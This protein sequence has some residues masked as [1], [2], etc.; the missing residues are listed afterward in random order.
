MYAIVDIETTG[1]YAAANGITEIAIVLHD[2]QSVTG[3]FETLINPCQP[4]PPYISAMTGISQSMADQAPSFADVAQQIYLLLHDKVF[5][6][7][8]VNFDYSFIKAHLKEAGFDLHCRKLCTIRLSRKIFPGLPGY[9]LGKLSQSL[10]VQIQDRH[11]AGGDAD[12]T[13]RI[14]DLLLKHDREQY[15]QK[16]LQ[17]NSKEWILPPNVPREQFEKLPNS[18]GVYFFHDKKG[19]VLYTGKAAN[20]RSRV[21]S[22]FSNDSDSRQKQNFMRFV[23]GISFRLCGTEL[24]AAILES[25]EIKKK[26]PVFNTAQKRREDVF[27]IFQFED[28][29]GYMRLAIDRN[30]KGLNPLFTF[31]Y[32]VD[33]HAILRKL[34]RTHRLCPRLCFLQK[35][36]SPCHNNPSHQEPL[37]LGACRQEES[38][39]TYNKRVQNARDELCRQPSYAILDKGINGNDRSCILVQKGCYYGMGFVPDNL[40][41]QTI[42]TLLP[43]LEKQNENSFIRNLLAGYVARFPQKV[44]FL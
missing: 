38:A 17:R 39:L 16:S 25:V 1:G 8:N 12:A 26:W 20:I 37:C 32:L 2:G 4:I 22:H 10:D 31:H 24:M 41:P 19:K 28:Q 33:G 6:A 11:R 23:H 5:V 30:R 14:F 9:G 13:A 34:V 42:E 35:D 18:P 15:I 43:Y 29:N 40:E 27:G 3:R 21:N 7:H 36:E 44:R